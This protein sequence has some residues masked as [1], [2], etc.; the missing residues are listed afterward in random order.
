MVTL[1]GKRVWHFLKKLS[2]ELTIYSPSVLLICVPR[3]K[4][5]MRPHKNLTGMFIAALFITAKK[6]KQSKCPFI[7]EETNGG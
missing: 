3:R 2:I 4:E 6:E 5:N 1:L 7:N